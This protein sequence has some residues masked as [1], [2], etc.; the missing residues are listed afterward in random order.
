MRR[1]AQPRRSFREGGWKRPR[2]GPVQPHAQQQKPPPRVVV[3]IVAEGSKTEPNYFR[4][5]LSRDPRGLS[6]AHR[7]CRGA[8]QR[9]RHG[10]DP[11]R[12]LRQR[13]VCQRRSPQ[14]NPAAS[15]RAS[16]CRVRP[17]QSWKLSRCAAAGRLTG[18]KTAQRQPA[19]GHFQGDCL[20]AQ[21]RALAAASL[22]AC[23]STTAP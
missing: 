8:A 12:R 5:L 22:R 3:L 7:E 14:G 20:S 2:P 18:R 4:Q 10:A 15:V 13:S 23:K 6:P 19:G 16:R 21:L 11:G 1:H 9:A 17:R